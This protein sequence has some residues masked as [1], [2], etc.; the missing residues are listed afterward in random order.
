[1]LMYAKA[2]V[3]ALVAAIASIISILGPG[4][5]LGDVTAV[6]W[7]TTALAVL[8]SAGVVWYVENGPAAKYSKAV[9]AMATAGLASLVVALDDNV[10]STGEWLVAVVAA[11]VASGLVFATPNENV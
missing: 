4:E 9:V 7:I 3:T 8:G 1:M 6:G 10:V 5:G 2:F 11:L